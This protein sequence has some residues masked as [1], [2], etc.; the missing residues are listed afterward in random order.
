MFNA[1]IREMLFEVL[2]SWQVWAVTIVILLYITIV[3]KVARIHSTGLR[4]PSMK[5][6]RA[7]RKKDEVIT[8]SDSDD[9]GLEEEGPAG[10]SEEMVD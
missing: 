1:E 9:L 4:I 7:K 2:K 8:P 6:I 3:R 10:S 5:K